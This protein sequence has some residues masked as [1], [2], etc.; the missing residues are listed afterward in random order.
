MSP[1][2]GIIELFV[3]LMMIVLLILLLATI[4]R[5]GNE[6]FLP[7]AFL[8][9]RAHSMPLSK[10]AWNVTNRKCVGAHP[11]RRWADV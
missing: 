11:Q 3:S 6:L 4:A 5:F 1:F 2:A 8:L 10:L 9:A 7:R